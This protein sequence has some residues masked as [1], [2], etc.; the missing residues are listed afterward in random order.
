MKEVRVDISH[1]SIEGVVECT[2]ILE[3]P[4]EIIED[5]CG[6]LLYEY[7]CDEVN[8]KL[9]RVYEY[10]RNIGFETFSPDI[11]IMGH[12]VLD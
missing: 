7:L 1:A 5:E 9:N 12:E 10:A 8:T 6:G 3:V 11:S 4:A 2:L